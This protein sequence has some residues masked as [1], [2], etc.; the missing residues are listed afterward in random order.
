MISL[1][2][3]LP[4]LPPDFAMATVP[5]TPIGTPWAITR[6]SDK[7]D[8]VQF[9]S[10]WYANDTRDRDTIRREVL[11]AV[12]DLIR[13]FGGDVSQMDDDI[14]HSFD[15]WP[16]FKHVNPAAIAAG[17]YD[18]LEALQGSQSTYYVGGLLDFELVE[19]IIRYSK[20]LVSER[21]P[22]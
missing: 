9:Y 17:F 16:Y 8:L 22:V 15:C 2:I 1:K 21:F 10:R 13:R 14:W 12:R 6:Q 7:S 5:L 11:E 18:Q 19:R 20:K 4:N 3:R